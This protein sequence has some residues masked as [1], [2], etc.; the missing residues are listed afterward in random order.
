MIG[1]GYVVPLLYTVDSSRMNDLLNCG[2]SN[3]GAHRLA[4]NVSSRAHGHGKIQPVL[5]SVFYRGDLFRSST[6]K[7]LN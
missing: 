7:P 1:A 2:V 6:H 4:A 5:V 3:G